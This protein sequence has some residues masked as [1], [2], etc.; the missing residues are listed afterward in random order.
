MERH[1]IRSLADIQSSTGGGP[2][3]AHVMLIEHLREAPD[4]HAALMKAK[5]KHHW[6]VKNPGQVAAARDM[7]LALGRMA[8]ALAAIRGGGDDLGSAVDDLEGYAKEFASQRVFGTER[9]RGAVAGPALEVVRCARA[10][11]ANFE[12]LND[13]VVD[14]LNDLVV[15]RLND[16]VDAAAGEVQRAREL[17]VRLDPVQAP[18]T[19]KSIKEIAELAPSDEDTPPQPEEEAWCVGPVVVVTGLEHMHEASDLYFA[20]LRN[21]DAKGWQVLGAENVRQINELDSYLQCL[22]GNLKKLRRSEILSDA[23]ARGVVLDELEK[24][25][26]ALFEVASTMPALRGDPT[27][28]SG[29]CEVPGQ[30]HNLV[31]QAR[32]QPIDTSIVRQLARNTTMNVWQ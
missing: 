29:A 12:N 13:L 15:D 31:Q 22:W 25:A 10:V 19:V 23:V 9:T 14:P 26:Y 11:L 24:H 30:I 17:R 1:P 2:R 32:A 7:E 20:L 6:T 21:R 3:E 4:V 5:A 18:L 16:L 27:T 8:G 28:M